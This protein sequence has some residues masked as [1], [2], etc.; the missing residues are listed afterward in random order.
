MSAQS[1][2]GLWHKAVA[3]ATPRNRER[4]PKCGSRDF[5]RSH[6]KNL[7]EFA[8]SAFVLPY[9]CS[10]CYFRFFRSNEAAASG[11]AKRYRSHYPSLQHAR[12]T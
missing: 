5:L 3:L 8:I 9:R 12:R 1:Y 7:I 10:H 6:R 11:G 4:C 2:S